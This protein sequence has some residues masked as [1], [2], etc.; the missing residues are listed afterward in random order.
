MMYFYMFLQKIFACKCFL[1]CSVFLPASSLSARQPAHPP[2]QTRFHPHQKNARCACMSRFARNGGHRTK[3]T[4]HTLCLFVVGSTVLLQPPPSL[5]PLA[6]S[7]RT[8]LL[9]Q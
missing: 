5:S 9:F 1:A 4:S 2:R 6:P 8:S 7:F 3:Q